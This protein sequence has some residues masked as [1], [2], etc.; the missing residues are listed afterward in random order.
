MDLT[1]FHS[2]ISRE[3]A[4]LSLLIPLLYPS[5]WADSSEVLIEELARLV[6]FALEIKSLQ[7]TAIIF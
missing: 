4:L 3:G 1:N 7:P 2:N 5:V 6:L